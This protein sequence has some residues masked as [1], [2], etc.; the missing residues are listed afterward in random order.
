MFLGQPAS[1][2]PST[3][4][5]LSAFQ[6]LANDPIF[7]SSLDFEYGETLIA[8]AESEIAL[9]SKELIN[10]SQLLSN[11]ATTNGERW[12]IFGGEMSEIRTR[13]KVLLARMKEAEDRLE[14]LEKQ[15]VKL[16]L[17]FKEDV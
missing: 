13:I 8:K 15:K 11:N 16:K 6:L 14:K 10:L 9:A 7:S 3:A 17:V 5:F 4:V 1:I 12:W 2:L